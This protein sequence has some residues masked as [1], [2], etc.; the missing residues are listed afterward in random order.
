MTEPVP[1]RETRFTMDTSSIKYGPGA[2]REVG[3]DMARLG[4]RRVL[5]VTDPRLAA[6]ESVATVCDALRGEGIDAVLYD[7]TRVEPTDISFM[8]AASFA[9]EGRSTATSRSAAAA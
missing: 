7:R 1:L 3:A 5:V 2:T 9:T 8:E 4:A 6:G